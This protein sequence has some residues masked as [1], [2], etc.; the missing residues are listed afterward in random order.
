MLTGAFMKLGRIKGVLRPAL[1]PVLPT[2]KD[3]SVC[4]CDS[5]ANV[6]CTSKQLLEYAK[7]VLIVGCG[8]VGGYA[9]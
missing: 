8:G 4:I 3:T 9:T 1:C 6:D 2:L 5:G 7:K